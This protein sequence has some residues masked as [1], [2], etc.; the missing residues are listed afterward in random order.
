MDQELRLTRLRARP[1]SLSEFITLHSIICGALLIPDFAHDGDYFLVDTVDTDMFLQYPPS[2]SNSQLLKARF[3]TAW[4]SSGH[5]LFISA[6][7]LASKVICDSTYSN[8]SW[9][10]VAQGMFQ[11]REINQMECKMYQYLEWEL[12]V[13]PVTLREFEDMVKNL[14]GT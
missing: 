10:I 9:S 13:D 8:K 14:R 2:S 6:F 7:M 1:A 11:L 5:R 4:G 3:P 12:N